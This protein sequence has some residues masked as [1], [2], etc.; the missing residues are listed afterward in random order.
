MI[1]IIA[2]VISVIVGFTKRQDYIQ[3]KKAWKK[4][5]ENGK[6]DI[7][8]IYN[9]YKK[10]E[11]E[12]ENIKKGTHLLSGSTGLLSEDDTN[13]DVPETFSVAVKSVGKTGVTHVKIYGVLN[14]GFIFWPCFPSGYEKVEVIGEE[15]SV[16]TTMSHYNAFGKVNPGDELEFELDD[17]DPEKI[18]PGY[19]IN[20][21]LRNMLKE[22]N[23][24][25]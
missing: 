2:A 15:K 24:S 11:A 25:L 19:I 8:D 17:I 13:S 18:K 12:I 6:C 4:I 14:T 23:S 20:G 22:M 1:F 16:A 10:I 5:T 9:E 7:G 3:D 21:S